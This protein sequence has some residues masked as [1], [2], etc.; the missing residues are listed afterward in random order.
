M[1]LPG[2]FAQGASVIPMA[3]AGLKKKADPPGPTGPPPDPWSN[4]KSLDFGSSNSSKYLNGGNNHNFSW[5]SAFSFSMWVKF[6]TSAGALIFSKLT[7]GITGWDFRV[8]SGKFQ[9]Y[10]SPNGATNRIQWITSNTFS[11]DTW[12]H[13][14][15][16]FSGNQ[17]AT[18]FKIYVNG[19]SETISVQFNTSAADWTTSQDLNVSGYANGAGAY[20]NGLLDEMTIWN[21]ELSAAEVT[22]LYNSGVPGDPS[23]LAFYSNNTSYYRFGD[24]TDSASSVVDRGSVGGV[25]LT[26]VNLV[27]GDFVTDVKT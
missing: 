18:G 10:S 13:V 24:L 5:A 19:S 17:S 6:R 23:V 9:W 12:Y 20:Y 11:I 14:V 2:G 4:A 26:G 8:A 22:S 7:S 27:S 25:N 16:T 15:V 21:K 3:I 1:P